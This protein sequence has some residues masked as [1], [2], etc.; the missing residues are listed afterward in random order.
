MGYSSQ[1]LNGTHDFL[2]IF[3][4]SRNVVVCPSVVCEA[5]YQRTVRFLQAFR[6]RS[7]VRVGF[8]D[9]DVSLESLSVKSSQDHPLRQCDPRIVE[10]RLR[11]IHVSLCRK[12]DRGF[13]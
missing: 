2:D 5:F 11:A 12:V 4:E 13:Y 9:R 7:N 8:S 1:V 6:G 10:S 3:R